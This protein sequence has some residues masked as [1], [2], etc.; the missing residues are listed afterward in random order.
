MQSKIEKENSQ[1]SFKRLNKT[2]RFTEN[3]DKMLNSLVEK[4]KGNWEKIGKLMNRNKRV[5]K[6]RYENYLI[7]KHSLWQWTFE[8]KMQLIYMKIILNYRWETINKV[9]PSRGPK[10]IKNQ[11]YYLSKKPFVQIIKKHFTTPNSKDIC[12][13]KDTDNVDETY[14][15]NSDEIF[16]IDSYLLKQLYSN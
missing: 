9:F 4:F 3:E 2:K 12:S 1:L 15:D 8:E 7:P 16:D 14:V 10:T 13:Q 11:W 5:C 6:E